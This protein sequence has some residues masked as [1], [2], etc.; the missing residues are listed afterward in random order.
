MPAVHSNIFARIVHT[1]PDST[2]GLTNVT[3]E[4]ELAGQSEGG[5]AWFAVDATTPANVI[6][7]SLQSQLAAYVSD[8]T[9]LTFAAN[10]VIGI[11]L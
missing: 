2:T 6:A 7:S 5:S 3:I 9:G 10:D 1:G 4:W 11:S 8:L